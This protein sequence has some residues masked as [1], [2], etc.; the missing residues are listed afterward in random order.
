MV[1]I[2]L[3]SWTKRIQNVKAVLQSALNQTV[4]ADR[5]YLNLSKEEFKDI[6]L[7]KDLVAFIDTNP[8]IILNWVEGP[9][10]KAFKKIFPILEYL[11]DN[12]IILNTDDDLLLPPNFIESR[13]KDFKKFNTVITGNTT[14]I[15]GYCAG[16]FPE[17]N[18]YVTAGCLYQKKMF[19][20][21]DELI[22]E[23]IIKTNHDDA[24]YDFLIW[25]NGYIPQVC[26]SCAT[27]T[28]QNPFEHTPALHGTLG[29]A[30]CPE[31]T[32]LNIKRFKEVYKEFPTFNYFGGNRKQNKMKIKIILADRIRKAGDNAEY[33]YRYLQTN[34]PGI[35]LRYILNKGSQD[36][37]RLQKDKF[38]LVDSTN[39]KTVQAELDSANYFCFSYFAKNTL[40]K[41]DTRR[42]INIFLNHG[43]FYRLTSYLQDKTDLF[44]LMIAGNRLEYDTLI[45]EYKFRKNKIVLT[46][47][48]RHDSLVEKSR[49]V[50]PANNI[51]IQFWWRP[52]YKRA[53]EK[54]I[55]SDFYKNVYK[56]LTDN[57]IKQF[58]E[59]Y[60]IN[61]LLK[62]HCEM[63][64]YS[65]LFKNIKNIEL[66]D[67]NAQFEP[68]FL[69]STM[70]V[71]DF[72]SNVYEMALIN[73]PCIY[74]RPDWPEMNR[75][76]IAKDGSS[77]DVT[78]KGIG[79]V[80]DTV[81]AFFTQL[82]T[83]I[84]NNYILDKKY[85]DIRAAQ[86]PFIND[87]NCCERIL[88]AILAL[89]KKQIK[90]TKVQQIIKKEK[91]QQEQVDKCADGRSNTY[92]YF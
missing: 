24:F 18:Y 69:K 88:A 82:E 85:L 23:D 2:T 86:L 75:Q 38:N 5:I 66:I 34:W 55:K 29:C 58:K 71:T 80:T 45:N 76:L 56:L 81:D 16:V 26:S 36:W 65:D 20:H 3:T 37:A 49:T 19:K 78:K 10:I 59:K 41:L 52:W 79:P 13:L 43:V 63:E 35:E 70:L 17:F 7:P 30:T 31:A 57:R 9:N 28:F 72:T 11:N 51:L 61:F 60:N 64:E 14:K 39:I 74:F 6:A 21:W 84:N 15:D 91:A 50:Q 12:D 67:N 40:S 32:F 92:L 48:A 22:C 54:F 53:K 4:K 90:E 33:F 46:G 44:D 89:P 47:Q 62:L 77:F 1:V 8:K 42:S 87:T 73:K 27:S 68:L 83:L 25:L